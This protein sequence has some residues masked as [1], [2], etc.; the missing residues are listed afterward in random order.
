MSKKQK[1]TIG[2]WTKDTVFICYDK[3]KVIHHYIGCKR[4]KD[5]VVGIYDLVDEIFIP[6]SSNYIN[7][8]NYIDENKDF[9]D[10][11]IKIK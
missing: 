9:I 10:T 7:N 1:Y 4:K 8:D 11:G 5:G 3:D 6:E 2:K